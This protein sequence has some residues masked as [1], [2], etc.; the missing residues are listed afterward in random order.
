MDADAGIY[1][2]ANKDDM[3][4]IREVVVVEG[5]DDVAAVKRACKAQTLV[6]SGLGISREMLD[7]IRMAKERCG[8]IV[9][10]DPDAPGAKIRHIIEGAVPGC[11]HAYL[12]RDRRDRS[13]GVGVEYASP[14]EILAALQ[15]AKAT[16]VAKRQELF[17]QADMLELGLSGGLG[18]RAKRDR[19]ARRLGLGQT[20]GKQFL[21]RLN[22]YGISRQ[23]VFTAIREMT[24]DD[25][26]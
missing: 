17:T 15:A 16:L 3:P 14:A 21:R 24:G 7:E 4:M 8:V 11:K 18:A 9:L 20:N 6:T 1:T 22:A 26:E 12:Y 25:D 13:R 5:K 10:T 2:K 19:L 23:E